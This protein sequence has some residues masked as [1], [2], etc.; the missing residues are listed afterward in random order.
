MEKTM[1]KF[2]NVLKYYDDYSKLIFKHVNLEIKNEIHAIVGPNGCGKTSL[3]KMLAGFESPSRGKILI[4]NLKNDNFSTI[5]DPSKM[6]NFAMAYAGQDDN[7]LENLTVKQN[8]ILGLEPTK[9]GLFPNLKEAEFKINEIMDNYKIKLNLDKFVR[10]LAIEELK[11]LS[12]LRALFKAPKI[13]LLDEPTVGLS[14]NQKAEFWLIFKNLRNKDITIIFT[15]RDEEFAQNV[16][17]RVSY[18]KKNHIGQT[19]KIELKE[20]VKLFSND[21]WKGVIK[22]EKPKE[23]DLVP[24]LYVNDFFLNDE[25][26]PNFYNL[27]FA[28]RPGEIYGIYDY[29]NLYSEVLVDSLVNL[30]PLATKRIW[31]EEKEITFYNTKKFSKLNINWVPGQYFKKA[32]L[33]EE[34]LLNNFTFWNYN[35][36]DYVT[37]S[38][39]VKQFEVKTKVNNLIKE[40]GINVTNGPYTIAN[41]LSKGELQKFTLARSIEENPKL[42]ILSNPFSDLDKN[43]SKIVIKKILQL[44]KNGNGILIIDTDPYLLELLC[45]RVAIIYKKEFVCK[46]KGKEVKATNMIN[47]VLWHDFPLTNEEVTKTQKMHELPQTK[48][49]V[50]K[51]RIRHVVYEIKKPLITVKKWIKKQVKKISSKWG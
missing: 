31:F 27:E 11:K 38:G 48:W 44:I 21:Y 7:F 34:N 5:N 33:A 29:E 24:L 42:L 46:L 19:K 37:K 39:V 41:N 10:D 6:F 47:P 35:K 18:I 12:L 14:D 25:K 3:I 43:S 17:N 49:F 8:I 9:L 40:Y 15:T 16:A 23:N 32:I 1:V 50:R 4:K 13:L 2:N 28:I 22:F 51:Q 26:I 45:Q 36:P 20:N 30:N